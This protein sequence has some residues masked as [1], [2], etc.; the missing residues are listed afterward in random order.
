MALK[1]Y[2]DLRIK[3]GLKYCGGCNPEYDRVALAKYIEERL[4]GTIEFVGP[5]GEDIGIVL[6]VEGCST[7]C[8]DL[9]AFQ[10]MEIRI[11]TGIEEAKGF[12][13]E[14]KEREFS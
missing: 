14:M 6:A 2:K 3:I 5:E 4:Q 7:A 12:I 10:G 11:I 8:A 9:T 1:I 13:K